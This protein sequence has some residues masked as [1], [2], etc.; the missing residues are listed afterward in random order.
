MIVGMVAVSGVSRDN[1]F[2][3]CLPLSPA[4]FKFSK[5]EEVDPQEARLRRVEAELY[6]LRLYRH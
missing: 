2:N 1:L 6:R 5:P 4:E 3:G